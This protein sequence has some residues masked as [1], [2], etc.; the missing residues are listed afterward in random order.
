[1]GKKK[2]LGRS[3]FKTPVAWLVAIMSGI[4]SWS[5]PPGSR[6]QWRLQDGTD[7][8]DAGR[9][10]KKKRGWMPE[11]KLLAWS[12]T[13]IPQNCVIWKEMTPFPNHHVRYLGWRFTKPRQHPSHFFAYIL[14]S[15]VPCIVYKSYYSPSCESPSTTQEVRCSKRQMPRW[16]MKPGRFSNQMHLWSSPGAQ[17]SRC[18]AQ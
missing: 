9:L 1:M 2:I 10:L 11:L 14:I 13:W 5:S 12:L 15:T 8:C 17:L 3:N 4:N 6:S 7:P 18:A 16:N